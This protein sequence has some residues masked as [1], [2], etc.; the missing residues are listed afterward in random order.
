MKQY[1]DTTYATGTFNEILEHR[2]IG[3]YYEDKVLDISTASREGDGR[4]FTATVTYRKLD[5]AGVNVVA[6]YDIRF[7]SG[8]GAD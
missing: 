8:K 2:S 6:G 1:I 4:L 7:Q 5:K 3:H